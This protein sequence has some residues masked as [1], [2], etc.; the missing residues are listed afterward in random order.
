MLNKC[1]CTMPLFWFSKLSDS[2]SL[3]QTIHQEPALT[4]GR[5]DL[6]PSYQPVS[7]PLQSLLGLFL[8][9]HQ[10]LSKQSRRVLR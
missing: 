5:G 9:G 7:E 8:D 3:Q 2:S 10:T 6:P 4:L 1:Y